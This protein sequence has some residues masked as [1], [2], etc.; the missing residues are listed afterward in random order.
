MNIANCTKCNSKWETPKPNITH[1]PFCEVE[2]PDTTENFQIQDGVL[3]KYL[4]KSSTITLPKGITT[5]GKF[6]F[7]STSIISVTMPNTVITISEDAFSWCEYLSVVEL[8]ES[9]KTIGKYAFSGCEMLEEISIPDNVS[10]GDKAFE[11][12]EKLTLKS[13]EKIKLINQNAF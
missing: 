9:V 8:S 3:I 10:I 2:L 5:I 11:G 6:A 12:C 7:D 4:G 1:C 13:I